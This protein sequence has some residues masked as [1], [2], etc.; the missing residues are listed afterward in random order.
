[1]EPAHN[2]QTHWCGIQM[3]REV[4]LFF[5]HFQEGLAAE[6]AVEKWALG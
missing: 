6:E 2:T 5:T 3:A 4:S 1:M